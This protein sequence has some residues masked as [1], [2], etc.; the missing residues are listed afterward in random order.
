MPRHWLL[1]LALAC[2]PAWAQVYTYVD[3]NGNRVYTDK[4]HKGATAVALPPTNTL[5]GTPPPAPA[6]RVERPKPTRVVHYNMLRILA[7]APDATVAH[8]AGEVVVTVSSDPALVAEDAY[9][10][11]LDDKP[12]GTPGTSPV[13]LLRNVDRGAHRLAV[14]IVNPQGNV[15]EQTAPQVFYMQRV[16][17]NQKR[18]THPC[19]DADY[20]V[21]PECPLSL[22][23]ADDD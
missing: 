22:K 6:P 1:W 3:A 7:P 13:M 16:S 20:G 21:R 10:L 8:A 9:E 11:L 15:I 4:P 17:L 14:R 23:P 12:T 19:K 2:A 5:S 18:R